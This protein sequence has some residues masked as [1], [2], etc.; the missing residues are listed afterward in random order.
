MKR[1][2]KKMSENIYDTANQLA[3]DLSQTDEFK[4]LE[5]G[6]HA[7]RDN[8]ASS[9]LFDEFKQIQVSMQQKQMLGQ[10]NSEEDVEKL[11]ALAADIN[12]DDNIKALM[13]YERELN[14]LINELNNNITMPISKLYQSHNAR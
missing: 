9:Q 2:L 3:K 11:Q 13:G 6:F 4:Q 8:E 5:K 7:V 10:E 1:G 14:A 12:Q